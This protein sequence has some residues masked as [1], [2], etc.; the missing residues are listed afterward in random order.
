VSFTSRGLDGIYK[1]LEFIRAAA[2]DAGY[3]SFLGKTF[4]DGA[5][6]GIPSADNQY[7][8]LVIHGQIPLVN[9]R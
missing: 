2:G 9:D 8:L 5:A 3:K 6:R 4:G 7:D 1:W